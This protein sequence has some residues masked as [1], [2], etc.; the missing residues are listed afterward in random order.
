MNYIIHANVRA[1]KSAH[2]KRTDGKPPATYLLAMKLTL[3]LTFIFTIQAAAGVL[4]QKIDIS[5]KNE[6]FKTVL[7][8]LERKSD[9]SFIIREQFVKTARPVTLDIKGKEIPEI[10]PSLFSNQPFTYEVKGKI[11]VIVPKNAQRQTGSISIEAEEDQQQRSVS[12]NV[13]DTL[14]NPL[15]NVT[16][17]IKGNNTQQTQTNTAGR[18]QLTNVPDN[19]ILV[20]RLLGYAQVEILAVQSPINVTLE[21][22]LSQISTVNVVHTGYQEI[23]ITQATGSYVHID[24]E[25]LNRRVSTNL[26]DRL[27]GVTNGLIFNKNKPLNSNESDFSIR[28]RSTIN[29]NTS[30]LVVIDNFPYD[31]DLS[32]INPNDVESITVLKDAAA[33]AIWGAFAG[34]GVIVITT[35]KGQYNQPL[36]VSLNSNVNISDKED[37]YYLSRLSSTEYMEIEQFLFDNNFYRARETLATRPLLSPYIE[38]LIKERDGIL[39]AEEAGRQKQLLSATDTRDELNKHFYRNGVNQQ[40]ALSFSGGSQRQQYYLSLGL[41]DNKDNRIRNGYNRI[42]L[43]SGNTFQIIPNRLDLSAGIY[44]Q[45]SRTDNNNKG[46]LGLVQYPYLKLA[47]EAGHPMVVPVGLRQAYKE[48]L[49]DQ[50]LLDWNYRP[51]EELQLADNATHL[52]DYRISTGIKLHITEGLDA[53]ANYQYGT[54]QSDVMDHYSVDTY[55]ARD[56]INRFYN[57]ASAIPYPIPQSGILDKTS[58]AYISHNVRGQLNFNR[59]FGDRHAIMAIAGSELRDVNRDINI[60]RRYGYNKETTRLAVMDFVSLHRQYHNP[61]QNIRI[62]NSDNYYKIID[63]FLSM[64]ANATYTYADRYAISGSVRKDESNLFGVGANKKGVPLWSIGGSWH[65]SKENFYSVDWMPYLR[66]RLTNGY[67]GNVA[68]NVAAVTTISTRLIGTIGNL[69]YSNLLNPPN[70]MLRWE[71][72][73]QVN[74]GLDFA[75]FGSRISG[76]ID[77]YRKHSSDL[78][79]ES[80]FAPS[81]GF[82]TLTLNTADIDIRGW[83]IVLNSVNIDK[84]FKW[85]SNILLSTVKDKVTEYK[86]KPNTV[87]GYATD[88]FFQPN[89]GYPLFGLYSFQW[90]GL[91]PENGDPRGYLDGEISKDYVAF[92]STN[93]YDNLVYQGSTKPVTF[94]SLMN[95][96]AYKGV[97]LSLNVSGKF[98]YV[99]RRNTIQYHNVYNANGNFPNGHA[100]FALRWQ[101]SG[102]EDHTTVP[103]MIYPLS[104]TNRDVF[105]NTMDIM[106]EDAS[107][108]RLE[109]IQ[110]GYSFDNKL[111]SKL[112]IPI[113]RVHL[114][115]YA[116]N[117]GMIWRANDKSIDPDYISIVP[118]ARSVAMGIRVDL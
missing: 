36:K 3:I 32:T 37:L 22:E 118:P 109:D 30:P 75:L 45:R 48:S 83:D 105:Y 17:S 88:G 69:P 90:A 34:N 96:F 20:F 116:N 27:D 6:A 80:P 60:N 15:A 70:E 16:V 55:F 67:S 56:M 59:L 23:P 79:A 14:G 52:T 19:A 5:A 99:F 72:N 57:P 38:L 47:D 101:Q 77:H 46:L 97:S 31:G 53:T 100:D 113:R 18:F 40:H 42:T 54:G 114:Y 7:V 58:R 84:A 35:K 74:A 94:G 71:R 104:N 61:S 87:G 89:E 63:R 108:I 95:T 68:N 10:L 93:D 78:I 41:D 25:L 29:A 85:K 33:T 12:G 81:S 65:I 64:Y 1:V 2:L 98:G 115:M 102:D 66:L 24:N 107:H 91:D 112:A 106:T 51:L 111:F 76:S 13:I 9:Y 49:N 4:A 86:L 110:L 50:G 28:G 8:E 21:H 62:T 103:S 39:T 26:I 11:I 82:S 44:F 73:R 43:N 117:L 92:F